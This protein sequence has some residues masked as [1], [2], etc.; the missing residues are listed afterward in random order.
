LEKYFENESRESG[1]QLL[2]KYVTINQ[3]KFQGRK[4]LTLT[5]ALAVRPGL[6]GF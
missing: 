3:N 6:E 5:A 4:K 1:S 2:T